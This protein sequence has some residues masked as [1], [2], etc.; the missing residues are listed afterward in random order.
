MMKILTVDIGGTYIKYA[1]MTEDMEILSRGRLPT[2]QDGREALLG[3]LAGIYEEE[4]VDGIAISLPGIIDTENGYV[5]MGGALRY[6]DDFYLRHALYQRC[7]T[8]ICMENDAK[9][10]AMAEAAAGSLRDVS[11]G[12]VLIFGTMIGG[13]YIHDH[14]LLRGRHFSAGEVSYITTVRDGFP[15]QDVVF[16][17]RC[18]VPRLCR[19]YAARKGLDPAEVD[20]VRLF[21]DVQAG[22]EAAVG[23]LD[24]FAH[25]VAVQIFNIQTVLDPDRFAIGGG[26]SAQP[27][28]LEA[29]RKNLK[30]L[31]SVCPYDIPQ[32][33]V[34][35]CKF[36]NDANLYGALA[37]F[38]LEDT[39]R[40]ND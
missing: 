22:D 9:C 23:C 1:R 16:G 11:D 19:N 30:R 24:E 32:A 33:E 17:N 35:T 3:T 5:V 36:Q 14:R 27:L 40:T 38:L 34:V 20:G 15:E 13:A 29:V 10:A 21:E 37:C 6:N 2:P 25:E 8:K 31:Y 4:K 39:K 7:R 28:F 18:G 12:F 26:I